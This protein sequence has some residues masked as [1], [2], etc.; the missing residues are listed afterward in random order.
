M[1]KTSKILLLALA[2]AFAFCAVCGAASVRGDMDG[3]GAVDTDDAIYLLRHA[4][5]PDRYPIAQSGDVDGSGAVDTD[6]AIYL[7]RHA[8]MPDRYP[9]KTEKLYSEGL[10]YTLSY[11]GTYYTVSGIG[12]CM[13]TDII[14]PETHEDLPVTA[15][16]YT[17]F[18]SCK[19]LKSIKIPE[20]VTSIDV[21]AFED[22]TA[23]VSITIP[24]SVTNIG[25]NA[26]AYCLSLESITVEEGNSAYRSIDG[27]LYNIEGTELIQYAPGKKDTSFNV[28]NGVTIIRDSAFQSCESLTSVTMPNGVTSIGSYA[29]NGC[30]GLVSVSMQDGLTSI[31]ER[32]F[33]YC[34]S[35][36]NVTIPNGVTVIGDDA[37]R[38]C[39]VLASVTIPKSVTTIG[40]YAFAGCKALSTLNY[41]GTAMEWEDVERGGYWNHDTG[42]HTITVVGPYTSPDLAYTLSYDGTYYELSGIGSCTDTDIVIPE[43]YKGLPVVSIK[44]DAF[45]GNEKITSVVIPASVKNI[46]YMAFTSCRKMTSV[47]FSEGLDVIGAYAFSD[48][49]LLENVEIP[50]SVTNIGGYAFGGCS[51]F[52]EVTVPSSVKII[53][54]AAFYNCYKVTAFTIEEGVEVIDELAFWNCSGITE[55]IIPASV[56]TIGNEAF[57]GCTNLASITLGSGVESIGDF[58][59]AGLKKLDG[60]TIPEG[61]KTLGEGAFK[62]CTGLVNITIENGIEAV[63]IGTFRGCTNLVKIALPE[64]VKAIGN[65]AFCGCAALT[66]VSL[67][68]GITSIGNNAFEGCYSLESIELPENLETIGYYAFANCYRLGS[69][70]IPEGVT[71]IGYCAFYWCEGLKTVS[72]PSSLTKLSDAVFANCSGIKS[73]IIPDG[74]TDIGYGAFSCCTALE[75]AVLPQSLISLGGEAF[76]GCSSLKT[77]SVIGTREKWDSVTKG[78]NWNYGTGEYTVNIIKLLTEDEWKNAFAS[79]NFYNVT[80]H[81]NDEVWETLPDGTLRWLM[82]TQEY[83]GEYLRYKWSIDLKEVPDLGGDTVEAVIKN[84]KEYIEQNNI[85][86]VICTE[87]LLELFSGYGDAYSDFRYD[88]ATDTYFDGEVSFAFENGKIK[89]YSV[90]EMTFTFE[91]YGTTKVEPPVKT[92]EGLS[93]MLLSNNTYSVTGLGTC[94][95]ADIVIPETY[96][97]LPVTRIEGYAFQNCTGITSVTIPKSVTVIAYKAFCAC[98]DLESVTILGGVV[99]GWAFQNCPSLKT[100]TMDNGVTAIEENAFSNCAALSSV[101]IPES[102]TAIGNQAFFACTSLT[103]VTVPESVVSLGDHVFYGCTSLESVALSEGITKIPNYAFQNCN[104]LKNITIPNGV[105]TV[106]TSAFYGCTGL[107]SVTM[108]KSIT[109]IGSGAFTDCRKLVSITFLGTQAEWNAITKGQNWN[110]NTGDIILAF[111]GDDNEQDFSSPEL[112]SGTYG[113]EY[114]GTLENGN[115]YQEFYSRLDSVIS[116]FHLDMDTDLSEET[117]RLERVSYK[118]LGITY[119]E[120]VRVYSIYRHDHPLYY[121]I[122]NNWSHIY[123][124]NVGYL[125][126]IVDED[127]W[128]AAERASC[129]EAIYAGVEEYNEIFGEEDSEYQLALAIRDGICAAVD[130]TYEEDGRTPSDERWAHNILGVFTKKGAVCEAYAETFQLLLNFKGIENIYVTGTSNGGRHAWNL[131]RM[132]DGQWYWFDITWDDS[133]Y[134]AYTYFCVPETS[135]FMSNHTPFTPESEAAYDKLYTLPER[136]GEAFDI[137]A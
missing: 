105:T 96:S 72:I 117:K 23:L 73:V 22:C 135:E 38:N 122:S 27:N 67:P 108:P 12:S 28:P 21:R 2:F 58:A 125:A 81:Y 88:V 32:A 33:Y 127:Y 59:F 24:K 104:A 29:F 34:I 112:Y 76:Y 121:W 31:G 70:I 52:T 69:I 136:A 43:T 84:S 54:K 4:L 1:K 134:F 123:G 91:K 90:D 83:D 49:K 98:K 115:A 119:D 74:I 57:K 110:K 56:K 80:M 6:D 11:D 86:D 41:L 65:E 15:I 128:S 62:D 18:Q 100:V 120:A 94:K 55:I 118:D 137:G 95:D 129:H 19:G 20:S 53:G 75:S 132:D 111:I 92:S 85:Y 126:P 5:M 116:A 61:V 42:K 63:S 99:G 40:G 114:L 60:I 37:F 133:S 109:I 26:F 106:G 101:T 78:D 39:T 77:I 51:G 102:V 68:N 113:Y 131:A 16:G 79:N 30:T 50:T 10:E 14:I 35:L 46:G 45:R 87:E 47:T 89:A 25:T 7:L 17:A 71:S 97:G 124:T 3:S 107:T 93:Y 44:K 64:S 66:S 103:D 36:T 130:Y 82:V 8:L 48:C 13:D 9:L